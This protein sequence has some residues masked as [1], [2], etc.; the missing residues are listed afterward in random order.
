MLKVCI[1]FNHF[2]R[3]TRIFSIEWKSRK[4]N[5]YLTSVTT[6]HSQITESFS[7]GAEIEI[8]SS[9]QSYSEFL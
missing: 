7:L 2:I 3:V 1:P 4:P 5:L 8:L 6:D 9:I